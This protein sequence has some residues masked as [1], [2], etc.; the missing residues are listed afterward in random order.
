MR[1]H[2]R[3]LA[4]NVEHI[5]L[6]STMLMWQ[7][8]RYSY[9]WMCLSPRCLLTIRLCWKQGWTSLAERTALSRYKSV[10]Q[11]HLEWH[12]GTTGLKLDSSE[13]N[14][15]S[16]PAFVDNY[17]KGLP[18][19]RW[20]CRRSQRLRNRQRNRY[21]SVRSVIRH[22]FANDVETNSI[23]WAGWSKHVSMPRATSS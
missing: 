17:L 14:L 8:R 1:S 23:H 13:W 16:G 5:Q 10:V 18:Y 22:V 7:C 4:W 6:T 2:L 3:N 11:L 9:W 20:F 12:D 21:R 19:E 15:I